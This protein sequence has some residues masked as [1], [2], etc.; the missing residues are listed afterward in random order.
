MPLPGVAR[1]GWGIYECRDY[2]TKST[3]RSAAISS[4]AVGR[5]SI[6]IVAGALLIVASVA[7]WRGYQYSGGK[8]GG[9][10]R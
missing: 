9:R 6:Y 2:L 4:E 7:G 10:G 5:Y 1:R 3:R 8:E